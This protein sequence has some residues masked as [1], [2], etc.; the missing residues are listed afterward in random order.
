MPEV[1]AKLAEYGLVLPDC[2]CCHRDM[3]QHW[4]TKP[5]FEKVATD[6]DGAS[7]FSRVVMCASSRCGYRW[8]E[9]YTNRASRYRAKRFIQARGA[10][11]VAVGEPRRCV[12]GSAAG[13]HWVSAAWEAD[14]VLT[15]VPGSRIWT[16]VGA[17]AEEAVADAQSVLDAA[18]TEA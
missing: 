9:S 15:D 7:T 6:D 3:V 11:G 17:T 18:T 1:E 8:R 5:K 16:G 12:D 14:V 13:V 4:R 10:H 2:P